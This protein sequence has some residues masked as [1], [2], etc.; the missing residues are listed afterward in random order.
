M[1]HKVKLKIARRMMTIK[2]R[3]DHKPPFSC[4]G[5]L[6]RKESIEKRVIKDQE[7]K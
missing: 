4:K 1:E 2:E 3:G 5:W 7:K 6:G